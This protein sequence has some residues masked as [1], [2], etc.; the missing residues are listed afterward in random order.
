MTQD[1]SRRRA[2]AQFS[3]LAAVPMA[4]FSPL[5]LAQAPITVGFIYVGA[6]DDYG[7]NQ[8]HADGAAA[9]RKM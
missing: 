7:Y 4:S 8:A 6:K 2:L 1:I 5:A 9:V 3:A